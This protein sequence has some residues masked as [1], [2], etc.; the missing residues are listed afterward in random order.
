MGQKLVEARE[1]VLSGDYNRDKNEV[2]NYTYNCVYIYTTLK[3]KDCGDPRGLNDTSLSV[4]LLCD[5]P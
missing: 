1:E 3:L 4:D 2:K 5:K